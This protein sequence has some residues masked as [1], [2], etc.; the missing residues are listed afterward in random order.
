MEHEE[1]KSYISNT[2]LNHNKPLYILFKNK[3]SYN[4]NIITQDALF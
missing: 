2:T 4:I 3:D 1:A